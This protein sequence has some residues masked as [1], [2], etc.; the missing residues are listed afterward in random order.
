MRPLIPFI[1]QLSRQEACDWIDTIQ[2]QLSGCDICEFSQLSAVDKGQV[3]IAIVAN[4]DPVEVA[5]LSR[6]QWVHSVW[7]GVE[8]MM[9]NLSHMPFEIV[10]LTDPQLARTMSEAV[11]A[12]VL[13]LHRD[14]PRYRQQQADSHWRQLSYTD[15]GDRHIALLGLGKLGECSALRLVDNG[16]RVSG[17][18]RSAKQIDSVDC[19]AG[20]QQL[21]ELLAKADI[22]VN[23][24]PLTP[25]TLGLMNRA[26]FQQ[27]KTGAALINFGR[28]A[29]VVESDLL[30]AL[31]RGQ[32]SH[33]VLDVFAEEPLHP[34]SRLWGH[35]N[36]TLLPHISAPTSV[37]TASRIVAD[38]ISRYLSEGSLPQSVDKARGY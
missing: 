25:A 9:A 33:A 31:D 3:E 12:W 22:I 6:L 30:E 38:N 16:F 29:T 19:Y 23:L 10:R 27:V 21:S 7:A 26:F 28:G 18:S 14:M 20:E 24:L 34:Q 5:Q 37:P 1:H 4:P 2:T 17:W 35:P 36:T 13:Y 8:G 32:L 11:L 15:P